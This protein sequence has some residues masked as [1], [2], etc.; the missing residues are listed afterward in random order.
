MNGEPVFLYVEDDPADAELVKMAMH[1]QHAGKLH[2]VTDGQQA[3]DYLTHANGF[4]DRTEH[5]TPNVILLDLKMP[6]VNGFDFLKWLKEKAP[7][8]LRRVPVIVMS[9][10]DLPQDVN[11]AYDLGANCYL[12][13]PVNWPIFRERI[14]LLGLFWGEHVETPTPETQPAAEED[15]ASLG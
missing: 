4:A 8:H 6:R 1:R 15:L 10:S 3:I 11:R 5:P 12:T 14:K 7:P 9:S 13:K 2:V